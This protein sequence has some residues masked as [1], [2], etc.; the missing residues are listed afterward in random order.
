MFLNYYSSRTL[1]G[2]VR[3]HEAIVD[4]LSSQVRVTSSRGLHFEDE[5]TFLLDGQKGRH[6]EG[7]TT[8]ITKIDNQHILL[9]TQPSCQ[10]RRR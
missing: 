2:E 7:T 3:V 6:I 10:D 4:I 5:D 1:G 8:T 9:I